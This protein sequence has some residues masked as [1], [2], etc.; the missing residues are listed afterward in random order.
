MAKGNLF[1]GFGR[2]KLGDVVMYRVNG[3]QVSRARNRSPK[4]PQTALQLLQ[5]TVMHTASSAFSQLSKIC[6]HSFQGLQVGTP[7]QS[8]FSK[9]NVSMLRARCAEEINSADPA[10]IAASRKYNYMGKG[11]YGCMVNPYVISEGSLPSMNATMMTSSSC[12]LNPL[13]RQLPE[14]PTYATILE[15]LG[16]KRGDQLTFVWML[17]D[18]KPASGH[19]P[20]VTG[21]RFARVIL[22]PSDGDL[23]H[24]FLSSD[25]GSIIFANPSNEGFIKMAGVTVV[26][27]SGEEGVRTLTFRL[28]PEVSQVDRYTCVGCAVILSRRQGD[29]WL[30]SSESFSLIDPDNISNRLDGGYLGDAVMSYLTETNSSLYLNQAESV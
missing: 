9:L 22:E 24:Y 10:T 18:A 29:T 3:E 15:Y 25:D 13:G 5:R 7:N 12:Y 6:D 8:R 1:L 27:G 14:R 4:N 20:F 28:I 11:D 26:P 2:G 21:F 23:S 19:D 17:A 30:R 16:A